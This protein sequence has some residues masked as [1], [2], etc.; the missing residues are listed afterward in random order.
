MTNVKKNVKIQALQNTNG[1]NTI[2]TKYK[3]N[4]IQMQQ[5]ENGTKYKY[6]KILME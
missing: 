2:K 5:N 6:N 3:W 1:T 4:N